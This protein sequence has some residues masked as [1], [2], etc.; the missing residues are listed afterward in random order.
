MPRKVHIAAVQPLAAGSTTS[1]DS[2]VQS[3]LALLKT[4]AESGAD[5]VCLPEYFNVMGL[6][7]EAWRQ[8]PPIDDNPVWREVVDLASR[9]GVYVILP[10]LERRASALYNTAL[11]ADRSGCLVGRY[12]KT[13]LTANER[14]KY[15]ITPGDT[16]PVFELDFGNVGIMTCY[17]GHFPEVSRILALQGAEIIFFPSLQRHLTA[18]LLEAQL[19]TRAV[20]NCV[21][22]VRSSYGYADDEAWVPGMM[23]GKSCIVD[24]E[25]TILADA[26]P[27]SGV[28]AQVID[29]DRPRTKER[30]FDGEIGDAA[31]FMR[32]DRRPQTYRRLMDS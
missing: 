18:S 7:D 14:A 28:C 32:Q 24:F 3:G 29:L 19:R 31:A 17:D 1:H 15:G 30:S 10:V 4:A 13:H 12:D 23:V 6:A 9:F 25:G 11:I 20:D 27:R 26:G 8:P 2:M 22:L 5:I 16:Y 21:Y